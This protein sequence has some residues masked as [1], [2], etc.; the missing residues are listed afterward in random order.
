MARPRPYDLTTHDGKTVDWLTHAALLKAERILG[1]PLTITQGSYN[2]G[3]VAASAGTH[4]GGGAVDLA[5]SDWQR[6]VAAMR[7]CGFAAWHRPELVRSG[8]RIWG[9]H[10]HAILV[11]NAKLSPDAIGQVE[12]FRAG[13]DGLV[14]DYPDA[15][16]GL[17]FK[18]FVWPYYGPVG[19]LRWVRDN[20]TGKARRRLNRQID[21]LANER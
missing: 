9:E 8:K 21:Q 17:P 6:K 12:E 18:R 19:R 13:G 14:G 2:V 1:Y 20:L 10:V 5:A 4:D 3:G 11:G 15:E 16:S 7:L